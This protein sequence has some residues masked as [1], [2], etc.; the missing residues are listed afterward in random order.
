MKSSNK[1]SCFT[2]SEQSIVDSRLKSFNLLV[3]ISK[4]IVQ[5]Q[6]FHNENQEFD[7]C[8]ILFESSGIDMHHIY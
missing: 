1:H 3:F 8:C 2:V 4:Q 7:L 6:M 5:T